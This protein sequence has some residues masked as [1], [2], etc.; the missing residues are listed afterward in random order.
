MESAVRSAHVIGAVIGFHF[1][2]VDIARG[3]PPP[4]VRVMPG[5]CRGEAKDVRTSQAWDDPALDE[6]RLCSRAATGFPIA[7]SATW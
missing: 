5:S 3:A 6:R 1:R 2:S 4:S 7:A